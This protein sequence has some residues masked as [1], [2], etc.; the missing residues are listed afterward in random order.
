MRKD[1]TARKLQIFMEE[2]AARAQSPGNVYFTGG[3]TALLFGMREQT[4]DLDIRFEPEPRGVFEAIASLKNKLDINIELA[5]PA[6]FIPVTSDWKTKSV[7]IAQ[8]GQVGFYHFDLRAQALAKIERGY[9]QDIA[10]AR[11]FLSAGEISK[12]D[13]Q[14]YL[15]AV[16]PGFVRYPAIDVEALEAKVRRFLNEK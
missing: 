11:G 10:D 12:D 4:I 16:K 5:S 6:D 8:I 7:F 3:A 9:A 2:L 13:F 15:L 14:S 1:V